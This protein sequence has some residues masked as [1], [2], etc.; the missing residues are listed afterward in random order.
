MTFVA[1]I[2]HSDQCL[3]LKKNMQ[4]LERQQSWGDTILDMCIG[5]RNSPGMRGFIV[6]SLLTIER[7]VKPCKDMLFPIAKNAQELLGGRSLI[8]GQNGFH[9]DVTTT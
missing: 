2:S 3:Q 8:L 9:M 4:K 5:K 6:L 7:C 1:Q